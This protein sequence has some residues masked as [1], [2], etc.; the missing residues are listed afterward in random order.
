MFW[1]VK[2][3]MGFLHISPTRNAW[4]ERFFTLV[5]RDLSVQAF[6]ERSRKSKSILFET[7]NPIFK[8]RTF[9]VSSGG[10]LRARVAGLHGSNEKEKEIC[11]F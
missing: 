6:L 8:I 3:Q 5:P 9:L 4:T 2:W 7:N 11:S 10:W 1:A